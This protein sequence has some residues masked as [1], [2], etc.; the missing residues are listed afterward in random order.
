MKARLRGVAALLCVGVTGAANAP[1]Y[2]LFELNPV[3]GATQSDISF[4]NGINSTGQVAGVGPVST[5][6]SGTPMQA[7][8]WTNGLPAALGTLGGSNASAFGV[9]DAGL[10]AGASSIPGNTGGR[11]AIWNG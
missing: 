11:A 1:T 5:V 2:N 3:A 10:V 6:G 4:A 7:T 8:V 9:N